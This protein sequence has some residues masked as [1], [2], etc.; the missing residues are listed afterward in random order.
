MIKDSN[1]TFRVTREQKEQ[2][3]R[4]AKADDRKISYLMQKLVKDFLEGYK[5]VINH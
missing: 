4:I 2:L 3:E 5:E 1:I